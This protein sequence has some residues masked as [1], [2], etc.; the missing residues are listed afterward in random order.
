M[1]KGLTNTYKERSE[2]IFNII[3]Q[4]D[5]KLTNRPILFKY[6]AVQLAA[7]NDLPCHPDQIYDGNHA[8]QLSR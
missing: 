2:V 5:G 4:F 3:E 7:Q 6:R 8:G 1:Q